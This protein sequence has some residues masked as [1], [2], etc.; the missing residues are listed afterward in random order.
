MAGGDDAAAF[1]P[2]AD[3][4]VVVIAV[5]VDVANAAGVVAVSR[6]PSARHISRLILPAPSPVTSA[7]EYEGASWV[8]AVAASG[9]LVV[10]LVV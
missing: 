7:E 10:E 3:G 1:L 6:S 2:T 8:E 5:V 4:V 9:D